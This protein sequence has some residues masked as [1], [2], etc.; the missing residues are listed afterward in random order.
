MRRLRE[1]VTVR[2]GLRALRVT[3][4]GLLCADKDGREEELPADTVLLAAG[5][6]SRAEAWE[7]R[8][9]APIVELIGDC[10]APGLIRDATFRGYHA[11]L[12]L[13]SG[14]LCG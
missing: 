11:A 9:T 8:G 6:R 13:E 14:N 3:E 10:V 1:S 12:D 2:T 5:M 7:L 4:A